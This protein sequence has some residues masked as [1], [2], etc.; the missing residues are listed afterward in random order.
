MTRE[1]FEQLSKRDAKLWEFLNVIVPEKTK[2][3]LGPSRPL[4][5]DIDK[6]ILEVLAPKQSRQDEEVK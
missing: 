6:G 4:G 1:R 3:Q 2:P 5:G